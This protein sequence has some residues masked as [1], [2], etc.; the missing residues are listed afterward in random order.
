VAIQVLS[1]AA[2]DMQD[3]K[4]IASGLCDSQL[5]YRVVSDHAFI[6]CASGYVQGWSVLAGPFNSYLFPKLG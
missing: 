6:E 4:V 2:S 5:P 3:N 1:F